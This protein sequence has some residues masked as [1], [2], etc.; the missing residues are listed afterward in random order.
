VRV[1]TINV[2]VEEVPEVAPS[3]AVMLHEYQI[4]PG[5]RSRTKLF[6]WTSN[7]R[8]L[9][10]ASSSWWAFYTEKKGKELN[11]VDT[12]VKVHNDCL[13]RPMQGAHQ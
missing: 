13:W 6:K 10:L 9:K 5:Q 7:G 3:S 8:L 2:E 12:N 4:H 1:Y 11:V